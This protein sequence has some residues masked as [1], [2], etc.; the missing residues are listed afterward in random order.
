MFRFYEDVITDRGG[1]IEFKF[2]HLYV[3]HGESQRDIE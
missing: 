3:N 1:F 2:L